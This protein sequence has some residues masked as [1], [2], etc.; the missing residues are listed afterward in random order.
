MVC[1]NL[2]GVSTEDD[3]P[4]AAGGYSDSGLYDA[5]NE[6]YS[7]QGFG[8]SPNYGDS[9][10]SG[11]GMFDDSGFSGAETTVLPGSTALDEDFDEELERQKTQWHGGLDFGLLVLRLVVG[12]LLVG[13][14]LQKLFGWFQGPG[15]DG[16]KEMLVGFGF[17]KSTDILAWVL[18]VS[19]TAGGALLILGLFTP[20]AASAALGVLASAIAVKF[21]GENWAGGAE[22]EIALAGG[23]FALLFT[24]P[25]RV[26]LDKPTHW[27]RKAPAYGF[28]FL[29]ISAAATLVMLLV[30]R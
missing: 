10:P 17:T 6:T 27:F 1:P 19:E 24:G 11:P 7:S 20:I 26:A 28:V 18:A 25:G 5:P 15:M 8:S 22:T 2:R 21:N 3:R 16:A 30:F 12:G 9:A 29:L 23:A 4:R 13:H 14:G